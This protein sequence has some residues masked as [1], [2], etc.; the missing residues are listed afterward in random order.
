MKRKKIYIVLV[1]LAIGFASWVLVDKYIYKAHRDIAKESIDFKIKTAEL[2][3]AM[4]NSNEALKYSDKVL[5]TSGKI[6]SIEQNS[7]ILDNKVQV[8]FSSEDINHV[9]LETEILIKGR[10]VGY[11]DLLELVKIDQATIIK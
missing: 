9:F 5:Q 4:S 11:D 7:V 1:L 2:L 3:S 6:T 10:C 8:N